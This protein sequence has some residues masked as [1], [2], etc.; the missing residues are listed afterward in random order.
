MPPSPPNSHSTVQNLTLGGQFYRL[1]EGG[2]LKT[3]LGGSTPLKPTAI[4]T[5]S[6]PFPP[7]QT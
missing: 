1:N 3:E 4:R 6:T 7:V 5:L 2:G